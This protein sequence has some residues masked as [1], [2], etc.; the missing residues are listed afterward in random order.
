MKNMLF[1]TGQSQE[2][3]GSSIKSMYQISSAGLENVILFALQECTTD[4]NAQQNNVYN[5]KP[6][7]TNLLHEPGYWFYRKCIKKERDK[8]PTSCYTDK[9]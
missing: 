2:S 9:T 7:E 6:K 8:N 1:T 3:H 5:V 4:A